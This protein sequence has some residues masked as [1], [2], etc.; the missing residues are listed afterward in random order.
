MSNAQSQAMTLVLCE[1][2]DDEGFLKWVA[3]AACID[4]L[5]IHEVGGKDASVAKFRAFVQDP[6]FESGPAI[7]IVVFDADDKPQARRTSILRRLES[8]APNTKHRIYLFPD[9][10]GRGDLEDLCLKASVDTIRLQ[11]A[12]ALAKCLE[13]NGY[14]SFKRSKLTLLAHIAATNLERRS[15][16]YAARDGQ[17]DPNHKLIKKLAS[18]LKDSVA[19]A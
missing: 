16:E 13:T 11:C 19:E 10:A 9:N 15:I 8:A 7:V 12:D 5:V 14:K 6:V 2:K 17:F 3:E 18:F 4:G 1:G